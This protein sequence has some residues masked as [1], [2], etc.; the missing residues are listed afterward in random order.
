MRLPQ[1]WSRAR[2]AFDD[3]NLISHAGLA[4]IMGLAQKTG[5]PE[6]IASKVNLGQTKVASAGANPVG[7]ILSIIAGMAA[8]AQCIDGLDVLRAGAMDLLFEQVY[9]PAT[10]GQF[11][12]EF[13]HGHNLQLVSVMRAHLA[14]L[15]D[16][17]DLLP[18][19][20]ARAFIDIDSLVRPV[21][22][23]QKQGAS[24]GHTKIAGKQILRK[25]LSPLITT[26]STDTSAPVIACVRLRAGKAGSGKGAA[27]MISEAINTAREVGCA[28]EILVRGDSAY[29]NSLVA[30]ACLNAGARFSLVITRTAPVARAIAS[31]A[32]DQW[33][34]VDYPGAEMDPD[35]GEL[36]SDAQVAEVPVFTAF[37]STD[38]PITARLIVRR[39]RDQ[40]IGD[41]L[42]PVWRHHPF[43]TN[44]LEPA[45]VADVTHRRHAIIE[46]THSDL[47]DG[48]MSRM[49]SGTFAANSAWLTSAAICHNLLRGAATLARGDHAVARGARLR[50]ELIAVP[51]R[52]TRP[53]GRPV[54]HLIARWPWQQAWN[55]LWTAVFPSGTSPPALI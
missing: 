52:A 51:A 29:G 23:H 47:I 13:T 35:T 12:R 10:M 6:L 39:V 31:I 45:P 34:P 38:D 2:I 53:Q 28:G 27:K 14:A 7:K 44:S 30:R 26:I 25:G 36:T 42:F 19:R 40:A 46:T 55:N 20:Q 4:P 54:L 50:R 18:G 43:L 22:G 9:A 24:F 49:P 1:T 16:H 21:Y 11:L 15:A 41:E 17:T 5:L 8:G 3:E 33:V 48:P 32:E 37:T